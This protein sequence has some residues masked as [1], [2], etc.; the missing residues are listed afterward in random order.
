MM[1]YLIIKINSFSC[2]QKSVLHPLDL[3][4]IT[5]MINSEKSEDLKD[6]H[7]EQLIRVHEIPMLLH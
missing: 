4:F 7:F 1:E 3:K 6:V 5:I 2:L